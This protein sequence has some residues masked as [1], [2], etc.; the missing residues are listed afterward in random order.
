MRLNPIERPDNPIMRIAYRIVEKKFGKVLTPLKVIYARKPLLLMVFAL[1][2]L[3]LNKSV[4]L[5]A[6]FR[7]LFQ[8][9]VSMLNGC[10]FCQD[11]RQALAVQRR[12][13]LE[14]F[15][16]LKDYRVSPLFDERERAALAFA[17]E[18][19]INKHVSDEIFA[20][21]TKHF[22]ETELVELVWMNAAENYFNALAIP[23]GIKTD[24]LRVLA[25]ERGVNIDK[26]PH[27]KCNV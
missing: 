23:L 2:D 11:A 21:L 13:G 8:T 1:I 18:F 24:G 6:S 5:S 9:Y 16:A 4:T 26:R 14:K 10:S 19:S 7:L 22:T 15:Q 27:M 17:E 25:E 20:G 12:I 3:L